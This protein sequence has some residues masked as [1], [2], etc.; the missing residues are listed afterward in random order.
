[1]SGRRF[2]LSRTWRGLRGTA[3]GLPQPVL[4]GQARAGALSAQD[5]ERLEAQVLLS[6]GIVVQPYPPAA[7]LAHRFAFRVLDW[8]GAVQRLARVSVAERVHVRELP[9]LEGP[10]P[11]PR[12]FQLAVAGTHR[13]ASEIT[14]RWIRAQ[15]DIVFGDGPTGESLAQDAEWLQAQLRPH[16]DPGLNRFHLVQAA[17]RLGVPTFVMSKNLLGLGT[18]V[19]Q[20]LQYS[21]LTDATPNIA[22]L[23]ASSKQQTATLL[24][25]AGLP[26][27][28][29]LVATS[30]DEA[31]AAAARIGY[32]VV[33]KPD[34]QEQGRGVQANLVRDEQVARAWTAARA[35][36]KHILVE[37]WVEGQTHRLTVFRGRVIRVVRRLAGGVT[38]DGMHCIRDLVDL[39]ARP[40]AGPASAMPE[41]AG[42][43]TLDDEALDLLSQSGLSPEH[44]PPAGVRVRL[45]R[46]DNVNA[47]GRNEELTL[48]EVHPDNLQLALAAASL[49]RLD[50]AG[51]DLIS[52]DIATSWLDNR[53]V[54]CE[55][56]SMPQLGVSGDPAIY[57]KILSELMGGHYGIPVQVVLCPAHEPARRQ[58]LDDCLRRQDGAAVSD[59][60]GLWIEGRRVT[61]PFA[62]GFDA[63]QAVLLRPDVARAVCLMS[64]A[65]LAATGFPVGRVDQVVVA[66]RAPFTA[67]EQAALPRVLAMLDSRP[68]GG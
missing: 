16:A 34:D 46:R 28:E 20:R 65:E 60:S 3:F 45:R 44:V 52:P 13:R 48:A 40:G 27:S 39:A 62:H 64:V 56:N 58:V 49:M 41:G 66:A 24:R 10:A 43:V 25:V 9:G 18:G 23:M 22:V 12:V 36:S 2:E 42:P 50:F 31:V 61:R 15:L 53:A 47:G 37:R 11:M 57:E 33:V 21:T 55:V 51:I 26:A 35:Y 67:D 7:D 5:L 19:H 68:D 54:I 59:V 4:I 1:M 29:H 38:G 8:I 6:R 14:A 63:A 17:L 32:P 30:A